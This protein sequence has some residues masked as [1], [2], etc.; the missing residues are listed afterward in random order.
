MI[1]NAN[2]THSVPKPTNRVIPST[3]PPNV[4]P[5]GL[6]DEQSERRSVA[7]RHERR[8]LQS[9]SEALAVFHRL[10][11]RRLR[12]LARRRIRDESAIDDLLQETW[13]RAIPAL[14]RFRGD[15]SPATWLTGI[16]YNC[17]REYYRGRRRAERLEFSADPRAVDTDSVEAEIVNFDLQRALELMPSGYRVVLQMHDVEGFSHE[18][19]STR[20][21]IAIGTSK[22]QLT[23][24]RKWLR[25]R[26]EAG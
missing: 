24:G 5:S 9:G 20:L 14:L 11:G 1:S 18:D 15:A 13:L 3:S 26:L 19:I 10:Y 25:C 16:L 4:V 7:G 22:S 12:A 17:I 6:V 8:I 2:G 21:G 23:R